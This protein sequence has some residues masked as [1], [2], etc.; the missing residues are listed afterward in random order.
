MTF[1]LFDTASVLMVVAA[2]FALINHHLLKLPFTIGLVVAGLVASAIVV[3]ADAAFPS[4]GVGSLVRSLITEIDFTRALMHGM[5]GFLLFAGALHVN[6]DDLMARRTPI[7]TLASVG[8]VVSTAI[9]GA[10]AYGVFRL[11]GLDVPVAYCFVFG[12]LISPTDPIAVLGIMKSVGAPASLETKVAGESLL[13]DGFGVV[14][15][16]LLLAAAG[17][18]DAHHAGAPGEAV[19]AAGVSGGAVLAVFL[20]EVVGGVAVG[21]GFGFLT[22]LAMRGLEEPNL[23]VFFSVALVMAVTV[24][25]ARLHASGPLACVIAGLLI[26]NRGRRLAMRDRTR[27]ALDVVWSFIDEALNAVLFLLVGLEVLAI[28]FDPRFVG[29]ALILVPVVLA[30]RFLSVLGP[31]S[32]LRLRHE[33]SPGVVRILTWGGLKGA[34]SVALALSLPAFPG[35]EAVLTATYAVVIFSILV[36]G[37]TIGRVIRVMLLDR[38]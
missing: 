15:F 1:G 11:L 38:Q 10:G 23:E 12:A 27:L 17:A 6:F 14:I 36:Q 9:V 5:L 35:R 8:L 16:S 21:L 30:A 37:L 7:L 4:L 19:H 26:G 3:G 20:R 32:V 25:A 28:S 33:F 18:G 29:A 24:T 2:V 31:I 34:I 13:N 22:Y